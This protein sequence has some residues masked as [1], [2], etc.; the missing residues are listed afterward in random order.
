MTLFQIWLWKLVLEA[1]YGNVERVK[2]VLPRGNKFSLWWKDLVG[3]GVTNGVEDDW[4]Q[5]VFL[6]K[7][8]CGGSTR[9]WLDRW[10]GLAPLCETFPRIFKV[11]LHPECVIKDLGEWVNDTWVWRLAWRR[12]FF[13]REEESYNNLMEIITPVPITKEEDSWSFIDG[14]MF[15]VRYMYSYLYKNILPPSP[16][17]LC[18]VGVIARVWESWAPLKVIVFSWQALFGRLPTHGNLV[19]RRIIIDGEAS[20]CVFCNGAR[21]SENH[22][23]SSC[24][25]AWLVWSKVHRWFG[26]TSVLPNSISSLLESFLTCYR[27]KKNGFKGVLLVWHAVIWVLW[28][29]RNERIFSGTIV[30]P[31]EIFDRVQYVSWKWLLAIKVNSPCLFYEWCVNPSECIAR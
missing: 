25:T 12:N 17:A 13:I 7:L 14:G 31:S 29:L 18:S 20:F 1:K 4:T 15:T 16:L 26:L 19:R 2:L 22:L 9:F 28:R 11:S 27:K 8:G 6:K 10:V 24:A 30:E 3:L 23:F 5:H 21:E